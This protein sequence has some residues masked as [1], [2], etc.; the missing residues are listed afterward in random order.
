MARGAAQTKRKR[1]K[2][3][4]RRP[5]QRTGTPKTAAQTMFFPRLRRQAKWVFVFLA[6][7]FAGGFVFF[8]VGSGSTGIGDILRGNFNLFGTGNKSASPSISKARGKVARNPK[9][10]AAYRQ[11]ATAYEQKQRDADAIDALDHY[12]RLRPHDADALSELAGLQLKRAETLSTEY[13]Q[14]RADIQSQ[15]PAAALNLNQQSPLGKALAA[16]PLTQSLTNAANTKFQDLA[17]ALDGA[18]K[19]YV[20]LAKAK[21][22]DP[23]TQLLLGQIAERTGDNKLAV[24]AYKRFLKLAPDDTS[25][26]YAKQ[27]IAQLQPPRPHRAGH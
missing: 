12:T 24:K 10:A 13:D 14:A 3:E 16:D 6:L 27:R 26:P 21:P 7:V 23:T 25:A 1:P 9:D 11:L 15:M 22:T 19:T 5:R 20:R 17:L 8:G 18:K 4:A 2:P